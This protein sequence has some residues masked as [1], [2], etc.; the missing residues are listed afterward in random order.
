VQAKQDLPAFK[1]TDVVLQLFVND[2]DDD[3]MYLSHASSTDIDK[4]E[5]IDG[6]PRNLAIVAMRYSYLAR[7]LRRGQ[8]M[9]SYMIAPPPAEAV[10]EGK[11]AQ[12]HDLTLSIVAA[13]RR[14]V[15]RQ[16]ARFF[17]MIVPDKGLAE[18]NT[19][20]ADDA[21][22]REVASFATRQGITYVDLAAAF[23]AQAN[24]AA[25]YYRQDIHFTTAGHR[26]V[27][28]TLA[29]AMGLRAP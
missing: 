22:S 18:R 17:L 24:Q 5:W 28:D 12:S 14:E 26:L 1:P 25:L 7:L 11:V 6:G 20:C 3:H 23:G 10:E 15:E 16:G 29:K 8:I 27:A 19:C 2:F 4:V 9:L 21:L 13:T